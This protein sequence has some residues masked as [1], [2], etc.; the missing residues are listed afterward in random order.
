MSEKMGNSTALLIKSHH[1][2][3]ISDPPKITF[4][5]TM[6]YLDGFKVSDFNLECGRT[7]RLSAG[8]RQDLSPLTPNVGG[9]AMPKTCAENAQA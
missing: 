4:L 9:A 8:H 3:R 7:E 5:S 1:P 2:M 6:P